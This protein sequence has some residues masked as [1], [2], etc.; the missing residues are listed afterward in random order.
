MNAVADTSSAGEAAKFPAYMGHLVDRAASLLQARG[1]R[2]TAVEF[3]WW[4]DGQDHQYRA[5]FEWPRGTCAP[6][7]V[8]CD[9]R[10][11]DLVCQSLAGD[12]FEIDPEIWCHVETPDAIARYI[13]SQQQRTQ[14]GGQ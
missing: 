1:F 11:G 5:A 10:S 7:V 8:V 4:A 6:R 13:W 14:R 12:C 2:S 9:A 3:A